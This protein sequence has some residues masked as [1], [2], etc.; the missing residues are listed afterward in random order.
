[1][2]PLIFPEFAWKRISIYT[3]TLGL[4]RR[5]IVARFVGYDPAISRAN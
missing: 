5:L 1:M 2:G 4:S 3:Y